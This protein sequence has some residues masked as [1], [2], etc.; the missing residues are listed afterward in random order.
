MKLL[1]I[2]YLIVQVTDDYQAAILIAESQGD[3]KVFASKVERITWVN[4]QIALI[5]MNDFTHDILSWKHINDDKPLSN[6]Y[7]NEHH[8]R[9]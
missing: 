8:Y 2:H 6:I 5:R 9:N 4:G 1:L 3:T 7:F